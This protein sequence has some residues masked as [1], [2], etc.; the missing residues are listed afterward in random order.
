ME[1]FELLVQ[2]NDFSKELQIK[3]KIIIEK[4]ALISSLRRDFRESKTTVN[5]D[6]SPVVFK[7]LPDLNSKRNNSSTLSNNN[8]LTPPQV[9]PQKYFGLPSYS[10]LKSPKTDI[11]KKNKSDCYTN[12]EGN[13]KELTNNV[14]E[15]QLTIKKAENQRSNRIFNQDSYKS[16]YKITETEISNVKINKENIYPSPYPINQSEFKPNETEKMK[17]SNYLQQNKILKKSPIVTKIELFSLVDENK[18]DDP[19]KSPKDMFQKSSLEKLKRIF[20]Y[21]FKF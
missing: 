8:L 5:S 16:P 2:N 15:T 11:I 9:E 14:C 3:E 12:L 20:I 7:N 21:F 1:V 13:P 19:I 4:D 17:I 6:N 10:L 18:T